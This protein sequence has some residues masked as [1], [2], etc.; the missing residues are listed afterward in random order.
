MKAPRHYKVNFVLLQFRLRR[1]PENHHKRRKHTKQYKFGTRSTMSSAVALQEMQP[2][3]AGNE[4]GLLRHRS[5]KGDT[6]QSDPSNE[7]DEW[8][9][10]PHDDSS[11]AIA[12]DSGPFTPTKT[13]WITPHGFLSREI[14]ILDLTQDLPVPFTGFSPAYKE[15][16]KKTLKDHSFTPIYTAHRSNWI[17]LKYTITDSNGE[18]VA[19]W[20]H[21]WT[22]VGEAILTFPDD[23]PHCSHPISFKNKR[24][25]LRTESFTVNSVPFIWK[26]DSLWNSTNSTLYKVLGSGDNEQKIVVGK[27]GQKWWG[28]FVTGGTFVVDEKEIDGLVACLSLA[29]LLKK[30]RQRAAE[31]KNGGGVGGGD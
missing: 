3:A 27:Y 23:S 7:R 12:L 28:S 13:Y 5:V 18:L 11:T 15:Q 19:N 6:S 10:E 31:Q 22:S 14:K 17:G 4:T 29:V 24:W 16:V 8:L 25:G 20:K 2:S 21:P 9:S 1:Q 30:K 26:M